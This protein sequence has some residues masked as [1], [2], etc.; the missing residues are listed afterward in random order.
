MI[1]KYAVLALS[2]ALACTLLAGC[3]PVGLPITDDEPAVTLPPAEVSYLAPIG[4]ASLEYTAPATL[5][6][7][8]HDGMGLTT[9]ESEV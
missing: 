6:L 7:P 5:Y 2:M 3:A 8:R 4:D 9:V 1:R